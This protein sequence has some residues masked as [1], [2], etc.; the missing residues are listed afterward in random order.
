MR[1]RPSEIT[2]IGEAMDCKR[3]GR[4]EYRTEDRRFCRRRWA[5][6]LRLREQEPA[7]APSHCV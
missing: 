4:Y 7:R 2:T 1:I 6:A 3:Q 5:K